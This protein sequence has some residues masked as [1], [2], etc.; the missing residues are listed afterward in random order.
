MQKESENYYKYLQPDFYHFST[1]SIILADE[2]VSY[3][4]KKH[5]KNNK[6]IKQDLKDFE[7]IHKN[8]KGI[9]VLVRFKD[10][11]ERNKLINY[12]E[13]NNFKY[14]LCKKVSNTKTSIF[15]FI[16]V[17]ENA[18]SIEVQRLKTEDL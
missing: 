11:K 13:T 2:T 4:E 16:K 9:N 12:C 6:K 15:S 17:N 3:I 18:I 8:K 5:H 7:I 1:D 10:E 14:K